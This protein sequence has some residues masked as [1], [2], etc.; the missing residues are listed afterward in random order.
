MNKKGLVITHLPFKKYLIFVLI[1]GGLWFAYYF[2]ILNS[3]GLI[4]I[5]KSCPDN[6][7]P[8]RLQLVHPHT[9]GSAINPEIDNSTLMSCNRN[10]VGQCNEPIY[11]NKWGDGTTINQGFVRCEKGRLQ[12]EN[13]NYFYCK[14]L[15]YSNTPIND[16]G[17]V[18]KKINYN[19]ELVIDPKDINNEGYKV[20]DSKCR[21]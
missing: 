20:I 4:S 6:L 19:I 16:D 11:S 2:F 17:T 1:V 8:E 3:A 13:V 18:G 5:S 10:V 21:G 14:N 7:I 12:G 15:Y 9:K